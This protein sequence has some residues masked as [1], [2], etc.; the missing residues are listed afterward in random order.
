MNALKLAQKGLGNLFG[1]APQSLLT[2]LKVFKESIVKTDYENGSPVA[3]YEVA[4]QDLVAAFSGEKLSTGLLPPDALFFERVGL[5]KRI[6]IYL[7]AAQVTLCLRKEYSFRAPPLIFVGKER[8][9]SLFA[10]KEWPRNLRTNIYNAPFPNVLSNGRICRGTVDFPVCSR[11]T[12]H[13]AFNAFL[14]SAFTQSYI[15]FK[16][17]KFTASIFDAYQAYKDHEEWPLDDLIRYRTMKHLLG[18]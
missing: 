10:V 14:E 4:G 8:N 7:P 1:V 11:E 6:G 13:Q 3:T 5:N 15:D 12:I 18:G 2:E 9:Y 17:H 16:S